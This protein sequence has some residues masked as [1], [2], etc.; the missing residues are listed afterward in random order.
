MHGVL[1]ASAAA[2]LLT[3]CAND[4]AFI[5]GTV[6]QT[7]GRT[8]IQGGFF[9]YPLECDGQVHTWEA[10][11]TSYNGLFAGGRAASVSFGIA[12]A[13]QRK[14]AGGPSLSTEPRGIRGIE[15]R[16]RTRARAGT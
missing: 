4:D 6:T 8:K 1:A 15:G 2:L 13:L 11:A 9:V 12:D 5:D 16:A 10:I 3:P 14:G 7:V